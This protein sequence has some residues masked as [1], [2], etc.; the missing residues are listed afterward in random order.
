MSDSPKLPPLDAG[1]TDPTTAQMCT[2][3]GHSC[4]ACPTDS[5]NLAANAHNTLNA[6]EAALNGT[7]SWSRAQRKLVGLR[8]ALETWRVSSDAHFEALDGWRRP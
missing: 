6:V 3:T 7:G 1:V 2:E 4:I 8:R 5:R